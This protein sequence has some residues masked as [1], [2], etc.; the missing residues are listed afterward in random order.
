[1]DRSAIQIFK[2]FIILSGMAFICLT[3]LGF[4]F[5]YYGSP[6]DWLINSIQSG[7]RMLAY[8][9]RIVDTVMMFAKQMPPFIS[10]VLVGMIGITF[11]VLSGIWVLWLTK[12]DRIQ[13]VAQNEK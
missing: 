12:I 7:V 1:M 5:L 11:V 6:V 4:Q 13:G 8:S 10:F 2:T 3:V 9:S